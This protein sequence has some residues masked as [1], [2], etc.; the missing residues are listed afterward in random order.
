MSDYDELKGHDPAAEEAVDA[1]ISSAEKDTTPAPEPEPKST[2]SP[3]S[4][5]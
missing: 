5:S 4:D 3:K 1:G 2:V